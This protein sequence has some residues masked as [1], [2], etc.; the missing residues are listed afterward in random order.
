MR[1]I[2]CKTE[3]EE[4]QVSKGIYKYLKNLYTNYEFE[5]VSPGRVPNLSRIELQSPLN[6]LSCILY[7]KQK[8]NCRFDFEIHMQLKTGVEHTHTQLRKFH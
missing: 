2:E 8:S 6:R 4:L 3:I 1:E 5:Q 7:Y